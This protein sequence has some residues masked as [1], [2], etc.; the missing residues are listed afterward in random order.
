MTDIVH[1]VD[2]GMG[3]LFSVARAIEKVGGEPRLTSDAREICAADRLI[4][5]GVGAF[6]DGMLGL[7]KTG[8][9]EAV[10]KFA[11]ANKPL[12][13]ICLGMQ[14]LA[15]QS[16]E[17]GDHNGLDLIPGRVVAIPSESPAGAQRKVPFVGWSELVPERS[18]GFVGTPM[19]SI[20]QT[21]SVYLVHSYH[22][23]PD[24]PSHLLAT[25]NYDG[26]NITAAVAKGNVIGLQFHPEKSATTGLELL[27]H[28]LGS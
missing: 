18:D 2:Y 5:P 4:L 19:D 16:S 6:R 26:M 27:R 7:V 11:D 21:D 8:L 25:Y 20:G 10:I 13:G 17:F 22:F 14:M 28:F 9:D 24:D 3:N 23:V 15:T 1:I 12:L